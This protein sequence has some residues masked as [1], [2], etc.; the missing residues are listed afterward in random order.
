MFA[1]PP[2]LQKAL[3]DAGHGS[4]RELE[5]WIIAGRVSVNGSPAHIGQRVGPDDKIRLN[6]K[7]VQLKFSSRLPRVLMYHK[8]EG[9][10]VSKDDPEGRPSVFCQ[11]ATY[12][13]RALDL[14]WS[15]GF[16]FLRLIAIH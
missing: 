9:E 2:K 4:R 10:I 5:E 13:K 15:L 14:D 6:G 3:A 1:D 16:Q 11:I 7:L 12:E 8:P